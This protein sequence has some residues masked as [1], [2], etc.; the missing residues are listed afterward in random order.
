MSNTVPDTRNGLPHSSEAEKAILRCLVLIPEQTLTACQEAGLTAEMLHTP[1]HRQAFAMLT[2]L[3]EDNERVDDFTVL[4]NAF[5]NAGILQE[6]GGPVFVTELFTFSATTTNVGHYIAIVRDKAILRRIISEGTAMV[7]RAYEETEDVAGILESA[8]GTLISLAK[9]AEGERLHT[10]S[11]K[12]LAMLVIE[13]I[14][15]SLDG[16]KPIEFPTGITRL[17]ELTGGFENPSVTV[18]SGKP[19]DGK[20]ALAVNI[21]VTLAK[22]GKSVGIIELEQSDKQLARRALGALS[23]VDIKKVERVREISD[24]D[25]V[26]LTRAVETL[27]RLPIHIRDDGGLTMSQISATFSKW[28]AQHGLHFGIIDHAQLAKHDGKVENTTDEV[29]K[30]SRAL[31]PMSKRLGIPLL[32]LSQ[33]T[34]AKDG[35]YSTKNSKA[36]EEDCDNLWN[37]SHT[38]DGVFIHISKQREGERGKSIPVTW[39]PQF[40]RFT[41]KRTEEEPAQI[42]IPGTP[43]SRK[44]RA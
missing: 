20:T 38:D 18:I 34:A 39:L 10:R 30:I 23:F 15:A 25:Q 35:S 14:Q 32:V 13:D 29:T 37:I 17:D 31:K 33:V 21:A 44:K 9:M 42:E 40:Q 36:L 11:M 8:Q 3:I 7:A 19:S 43:K 1:A 6:I 5:Q 41:N 4:L 24:E 27:S 12:E 2:E 22:A 26:K 16:E 28:K